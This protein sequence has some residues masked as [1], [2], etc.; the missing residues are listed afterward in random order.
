[1]EGD[2]ASDLRAELKAVAEPVRAKAKANV[3][4][5]TGRHGQ[6]R[7]RLADTIKVSATQRAV[8]VYSSSPYAAVQDVG[9]RVGHGALISRASASHYM[10]KAVQ[11]SQHDTEA[12]LDRLGQ[13]IERKYGR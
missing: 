12:A 1:M 11:D 9:G 13:T 6:E 3:Q 10:T 4:H 7:T 8:S 2:L 5:K